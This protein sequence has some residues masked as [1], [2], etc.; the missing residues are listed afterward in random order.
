MTSA[1]Q[2]SQG[3]PQ[4]VSGRDSNYGM[5]PDRGSSRD[6]GDLFMI[7]CSA[8]SGRAQAHA[9]TAIPQRAFEIQAEVLA[10]NA[11]S[12]GAELALQQCKGRSM[13]SLRIQSTPTLSRSTPS[14]AQHTIYQQPLLASDDNDDQTSEIPSCLNARAWEGTRS[15]IDMLGA[16]RPG[17]ALEILQSFTS[18]DK[19]QYPKHQ[20]L[21]QQEQEAEANDAE[22]DDDEKNNIKKSESRLNECKS[23]S[24]ID[25]ATGSCTTAIHPQHSTYPTLS[26]RTTSSLYSPSSTTSTS[27]LK[28]QTFGHY[29]DDD[30]KEED[31][32]LGLINCNLHISPTLSTAWSGF[33]CSDLY[34]RQERVH[35]PRAGLDQGLAPEDTWSDGICIRNDNLDMVAIQT[36]DG[37]SSS[38]HISQGGGGRAEP[39]KQ[40]SMP[41]SPLH[42]HST[43][44]SLSLST[45]TTTTT[46]ALR[47]EQ[48][49]DAY[50]Q[51]GLNSHSSAH[52]H[53][54]QPQ[55]QQQPYELPPPSTAAA[56]APFY[57][58]STAST[59]SGGS[60]QQVHHHQQAHGSGTTH[61]HAAVHT[62]M[63]PLPEHIEAGIMS[64]STWLLPPAGHPSGP[65]YLQIDHSQIDS[66]DLSAAPASANG[67][68]SG[69]GTGQG[70]GTTT[71]LAADTDV[72][73]QQHHHLH[74]HHQEPSN[75]ITSSY[76]NISP[77][78]NT[79]QQSSSSPQSSSITNNNNP[80][81]GPSSFPPLATPAPPSSDPP[82]ISPTSQDFGSWR[83]AV[84]SYPFSSGLEGISGLPLE[85][86]HATAALGGAPPPPPSVDMRRGQSDWAPPVFEDEVQ[87]VSTLSTQPY[88]LRTPRGSHRA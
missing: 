15:T 76:L 72:S 5:I 54:T 30:Y 60:Q 17:C 55:H 62:I 77:T 52:Q 70:T 1:S 50:T 67:S 59:L 32:N 51:S 13:S 41:R 31:K 44:P 87:L 58:D 36:V 65:P 6:S 75:T 16:G 10:R 64:A 80:F 29:N 26:S 43:H 4:I 48:E 49:Q 12:L 83:L 78:S 82:A 88:A 39:R 45:S 66:G 47:Q 18:E 7:E 46:T 34:P 38:S 61:G 53:Y 3:N 37:G 9:D 71:G 84:E 2:A 21:E 85:I 35:Q 40:G 14:D 42:S 24:R 73:R 74:H 86:Y 68:G 33:S 11:S 8:V 69:T 27:T 63:A 28:H 19:Q 22:K 20:Q 57:M 56:P 23:K 81:T 25:S 79:V